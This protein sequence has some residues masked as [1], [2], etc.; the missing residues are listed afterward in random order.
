MIRPAGGFVRIPSYALLVLV[1]ILFLGRVAEA[2]PPE[3]GNLRFDDPD[4]MSW[5]FVNGTRGYHVYRSTYDRVA[6]GDYGDC[7]VGSHRS[8]SLTGF[9][10]LGPGEVHLFLVTAF[11]EMGEGTAGPNPGGGDRAVATPCVPLRR[12]FDFQANGDAGDG[13]LDGVEPARNSSI[14]MYSTSRE[15]TGTFLHTGEFVIGARDISGGG[16]GFVITS[17]GHSASEP[18]PYETGGSGGYNNKFSIGN[19]QAMTVAGVRQL[20]VGATLEGGGGLSGVRGTALKGITRSGG[21]RGLWAVMSA[22]AIPNLL[23]ASKGENESPAITHLRTIKAGHRLFRESG[24]FGAS[25]ASHPGLPSAFP[26][27]AIE[28][29]FVCPSLEQC[30]YYRV[31][32]LCDLYAECYFAYVDCY[33][34]GSLRSQL[35]P[36]ERPRMCPGTASLGA[37]SPVALSVA[38]KI[39]AHPAWRSGLSIR[40]MDGFV[41][42][43]FTGDEDEGGRRNYRPE[44]AAGFLRS[45]RSQV[46][47]DGPLGHGWD[48]GANTRAVPEA[49]DVRIYDGRGRCDLFVRTDPTSFDSPPGI[50]D[51]L[52]QNPDGSFTLR[53]PGGTLREF[54][55]FDGSNLEGAVETVTDRNGNFE[56]FLYDQQGL[57]TTVVDT[58]GR[59]FDYRYDA[60]GRITSITDFAGREV[61]YA[62][63]ANGDLVTARSPIVTGTPNGN[64]FPSGK[65]TTYQYTSGFADERLNH[66][67]TAII[68]PNQEASGLPAIQIS[69]GETAGRF[70][71][72]RIVAQTIG[73]TNAS[74]IPA[75]GQIEFTYTA[76]NAGFLPD[77]ITARR[78]TDVTDRNGNQVRFVHNHAGN[79]LSRTDFTNRDLRP[80]EPDYTTTH[81]YNGDGEG[82]TTILPEGN[83]LQFTYDG[84]TPNRGSQGNLLELRIIAD[85]GGGAGGGGRG[86]GHG[87][88]LAD[89]VWTFLYD[90]YFNGLL[91][92]A[93]PRGNDPAYIPQNGGAQSAAR[94][95]TNITYDHQEGDPAT[96]GLETLSA[97]FRILP[98]DTALELG[99]RNGD[100]MTS[101]AGG[102]PVR[103]ELPAVQLDP[104]SNQAAIEGDV[105]QEAVTTFEW[106]GFGQLTAAVDPEGNRHE[107]GYYPETDPDG[108]GVLTPPP[109]D[110]RTLN[111]TTGGYLKTA[112]FDTVSGTGRNNN[113]DPTPVNLQVDFEYDA[114]GNVTGVIDGRGVLTR[115]VVNALNQVV[116]VRRAA[117]TADLS[118]P[119]GDPP[120]GRGEVSGIIP[121]VVPVGFETRYA[122]DANNNLVGLEVEDRGETQGLGPFIASGWTYDILDN[123][124]SVSRAATP[125]KNLV[126]QLRYDANENP[127]RVIQ[128]EGN[129]HWMAWD[130]RD[131]PLTRTI[132]AAGPRGGVPSV[133][134]L[135]YDGNGNLTRLIDPTG[136]PVDYAHDGFDR[137][138]VTTDQV[139][140]TGAYFYDPVSRV[141]R[142]LR[143]GPVGGPAPA[144]RSGTTNVDLAE[145]LFLYDERGRPFRVDRSLFA[146]AAAIQVRAPALVEGPLVAADGAINTAFEYDR[147]SRLT[148]SIRDSGATTRIDYDGA[149]RRLLA[150]WPA[151]AGSVAYTWDG[152]HNLIET[153]ETENPSNAAGGPPAETFLTTRFLDALNRPE[154]F[155]DNIG[156]TRR[157]V[158]DSMDAI[159]AMSDARGPLSGTITRRS[160]GNETTTVPI[161]SHGNVVKFF[162]DGA[163]RRQFSQQV[164]GASG[165]G[166]GTTFPDPDLSNPF[167]SDGLITS[168]TVWDDN[169]LPVRSIDDRGNVTSFAY[170]NLNRRT[171]WMGDDETEYLYSYDPVGNRTAVT[172]PD[173][174]NFLNTYDAAHRLMAVEITPTPGVEGTTDQSFEYDGLNR[175][176][177][178]TD[179]NVPGSA[180]DDV[181]NTFFYDSM[182]RLVEETRQVGG[183]AS[184]V[185]S[186]DYSWDAGNRMT[187]LRYP[188]G[189]TI[190]YGFDAADRLVSIQDDDVTRPE[191]AAYDYFGLGRVHTRTF[192]DGTVSTMLDDA[193]TA[194]IGFDGARRVTMLR[195]RDPGGRG[196]HAGFEYRYDRDSNATSHRRRHDMDATGDL[197]GETYEWDSA[198]RLTRF[199]EGFLDSGHGLTAPPHDEKEWSLDGT[200]NWAE[201]TRN[202]TTYSSDVN[203]M[204]DYGEDRSGGMAADDGVPDDFLN[205]PASSP[206][207]GL[208]FAHDENRN[209]VFDGRHTLIFDGFNRL[210]RAEEYDGSGTPVEVARYSYDALGRRV[211]RS[212][213]PEPGVTEIREY[214]YA[215]NAIIETRD[216]AGDLVREIAYG[217]SGPLWQLRGGST[218][219]Y[220]LEDPFG[221]TIA[222]LDGGV[223]ER[224]TYDPYGKP[225]F[226]SPGNVA[227]T[228]AGGNFQPTSSS[229]NTQLWM[230]NWYDPELGDRTSEVNSDWGG[231]YCTQPQFG[232]G[233]YNPNLGRTMGEDRQMFQLMM[234]NATKKNAQTKHLL[235]ATMKSIHDTAKAVIQSMR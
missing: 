87:G 33:N 151:G 76:L 15:W 215:G 43:F 147:L 177:R 211:S 130:E 149:G 60:L 7:L 55:A 227:L 2:I 172:D 135:E 74:G 233:F 179:N 181:T 38:E 23:E 27:V 108:D 18:G 119:G 218:T 53:S 235:S 65:T 210:I 115:Y 157:V 140:N 144:D 183:G 102:N 69:Y 131:L 216:G 176:T 104:M 123:P 79:R 191:G 208:N 120:T 163:G 29:E 220:F 86:D 93:D 171:L 81:S 133:T 11:D 58:M 48:S 229:G 155:V 95:T 178:A 111:P 136:G 71:L 92:V 169:S 40:N 30:D 106:N 13:V 91:A 161:N 160:P 109:D 138:A 116:E 219:E 143:R 96:N 36:P 57:L 204:N 117:A 154:M 232:P 186:T 158:Y 212:A 67:L 196:E 203:N 129:E 8:T 201:I 19:S 223:L 209:M 139:G 72:D 99:D 24:R 45:Y 66:N 20:M 28:A 226:E 174:S 63:D 80:G 156:R 192:N 114:V 5:D 107:Y 21:L 16:R 12:N 89:R 39:P 165:V 32:E 84:T 164:L 205:D 230:G 37:L 25:G 103:V 197:R 75:G 52:I 59:S 68:R 221:S 193:G 3:V 195:H 188:D 42:R 141:T 153:V 118:G 98:H 47:Y 64:D 50:Y 214:L 94:Y 222:L 180:T 126:T 190:G 198:G 122:Y 145:T 78:Q 113:T 44:L 150:T 194:D 41:S 146:P 170:D 224:V 17:P 70:D 137:L 182:S 9:D 26:D 199:Q 121:G 83:R 6:L 173:G 73:G 159:A 234:Q 162:Y 231:Y 88:S 90:D 148:F 56:S 228:D 97:R 202:G 175:L 225:Q 152:N 184:T 142:S 22:V 54:H 10:S 124:L 132:G 51:V 206:P 185:E 166:N 35:I 100:G 49:G 167:N 82:L 200:S 31:N 207:A 125:V 110:I 213:E 1:G 189:R 101:G 134:A 105:D 85:D 217:R 77:P 187:G 128:P 61:Q 4:T 14:G 62:Y 112:R 127:V 34:D 168:T 46:A